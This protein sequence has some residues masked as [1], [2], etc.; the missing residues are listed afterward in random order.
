MGIIFGL[1]DIYRVGSQGQRDIFLIHNV[2][3][4]EGYIRP[5][6]PRDVVK[7]PSMIPT[8]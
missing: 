4:E 6:Y 7:A 1:D 2:M 5:F 3:D 8:K